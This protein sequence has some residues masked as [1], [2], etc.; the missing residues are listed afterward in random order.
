[1]PAN[2]ARLV[3]QTPHGRSVEIAVH[4]GWYALAFAH[5]DRSEQGRSGKGTLT[6][7]DARGKKLGSTEY[8]MFTR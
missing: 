4:Q 1:L 2:V 5:H 7:Y 3:A 8:Q 6:A